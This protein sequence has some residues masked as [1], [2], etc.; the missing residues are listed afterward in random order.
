MMARMVRSS[1]P[2][3]TPRKSRRKLTDGNS[4]HQC[5]EMR[6]EKLSATENAVEKVTE[7]AEKTLEN[8]SQN[9]ESE[10]GSMIHSGSDNRLSGRLLPNYTD[11]SISIHGINYLLVFN[12]LQ[13]V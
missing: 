2:R 11:P 12:S 6:T 10:Y 3:K 8:T 13:Q 1:M 5:R 9:P 4:L 7:G